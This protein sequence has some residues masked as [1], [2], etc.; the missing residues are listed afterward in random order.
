MATTSNLLSASFIV[1]VAARASGQEKTAKRPGGANASFA[2]REFRGSNN[3]ILR[4]SLFMPPNRGQEL[5]RQNQPTA[6]DLLPHS[7]M[8][9]FRPSRVR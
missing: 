8:R 5:A 3:L 9:C 4:Y 2:V 7:S 6:M 1:L